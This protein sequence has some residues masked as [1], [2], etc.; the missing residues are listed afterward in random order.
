MQISSRLPNK[1]PPTE[2]GHPI[3]PYCDQQAGWA[4]RFQARDSSETFSILLPFQKSRSWS[5]MMVTLPKKK[6]SIIIMHLVVMNIC[7]EYEY[8]VSCCSSGFGPLSHI[9]YCM[10]ILRSARLLLLGQSFPDFG[11]AWRKTVISTSSPKCAPP[12]SR[13]WPLVV[14]IDGQ[15]LNVLA[16][17]FPL[18]DARSKILDGILAWC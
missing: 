3:I 11:V 9:A 12:R 18:F 7:A 17:S 10:G 13:V 2:R 5:W 6:S 16:M 8:V 15:Y 14:R 4:F 1:S